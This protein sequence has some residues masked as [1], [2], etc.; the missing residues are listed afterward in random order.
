M[1]ELLKKKITKI[2]IAA[3]VLAV[4]V[5]IISINARSAQRQR[6]YDS[7]VDAA[8]KYLTEL[9]YE[10]AIA[11]YTLALEI[12]PNNEEVLNALEQTYLDYAQ[13][14]ADAGE[15]EKAI[16][17]LEEGY[18]QTG[19]ESLR[20]KLEELTAIQAKMIE[21]PFELTDITIMGYDLFGDYYEEVCAAYGAPVDTDT[22]E[23]GPASVVTAYG[24]AGSYVIDEEDHKSK[25]VSIIQ[26]W[27]PE[28]IVEGGRYRAADA[29]VSYRIEPEMNSLTCYEEKMTLDLSVL[30]INIPVKPGDSYEEWCQVMQI[31]RIKETTEEKMSEGKWKW[32]FYTKWGKGIYM[33]TV[34]D[35][36]KSCWFYLYDGN[37]DKEENALFKLD[38]SLREDLSIRRVDIFTYPGSL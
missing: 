8:E 31:F 5:G 10:Q 28:V 32:A 21:L 25:E 29:A 18:A 14:L 20:E 35:G 1:K 2:G 3:I 9:D 11:E 24:E 30:D 15:Y 22:S 38:I 36:E 34:E 6:E 26:S 27:Q 33:E 37:E 7:H 23:A 12:E 19:R 16:G 17:L 4:A 13:S